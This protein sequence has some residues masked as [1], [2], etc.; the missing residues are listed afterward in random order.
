MATEIGT[1]FNDEDRPLPT[2]L[3]SVIGHKTG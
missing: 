3:M 1:S 2:G